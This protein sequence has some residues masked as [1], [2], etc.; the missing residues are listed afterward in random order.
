MYCQIGT[1]NGNNVTFVEEQRIVGR[2][3]FPKIAINDN[4]QIVEVHEAT[5]TRRIYYNV[6]YLHNQY[7]RWERKAVCIGFGRFPAV[8]VR[9]NRVVTRTIVLI[10]D[11]RHTIAL[12]L[13]MKEEQQL[14]GVSRG[15]Y[16]QD[17]E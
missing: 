15:C 11:T 5:L 6:G 13:L 17:L 8:A 2:G 7:I 1:P 12:E 3:K 14:T 9:D 16:L 10:F 4:N